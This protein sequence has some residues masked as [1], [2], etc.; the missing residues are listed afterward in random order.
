[1]KKTFSILAAIVFFAVGVY[2]FYAAGESYFCG[3]TWN[4][5]PECILHSFLPFG[6]SVLFLVIGTKSGKK[7]G[8]KKS[9]DEEMSLKA[10]HDNGLLSEEE[11]QQKLKVLRSGVQKSMDDL[12]S[13]KEAGIIT[14]EEYQQKMNQLLK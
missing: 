8:G 14:D 12:K 3:P 10:L 5:E 1:M 9:N 13:L 4:F 2:L 6:L 7:T 11:Y